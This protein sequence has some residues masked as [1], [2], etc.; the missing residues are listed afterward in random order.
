MIRELTDFTSVSDIRDVIAEYMQTLPFDISYQSPGAELEDL[1]SL[2]GNEAGGAMFVAMDGNKIAGCVAVKAI[3]HMHPRDGI[4]C[5]EMK[6]LYVREDY[7]GRNLGRQLAEAIIAKAKELGYHEMYLD[8]H[9]EAQQLA[10]QMYKRMGFVECEDY[11]T[12]PGRLLCLRL[13]L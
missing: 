12:N 5:C 4:R 8:T 9:R 6:R 13:K 11:H 2:Y 3:D 10:I 7:R 1:A